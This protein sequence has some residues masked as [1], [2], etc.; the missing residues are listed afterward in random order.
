MN[1][2]IT[3]IV[4]SISLFS[5]NL[6][7]KALEISASTDQC[8]TSHSGYVYDSLLAAQ[9]FP[10]DTVGA[11]LL[12]NKRF[13]RRAIAI[14]KDINVY[15]LLCE[16]VRKIE[17]SN[18]EDI[19]FL[20][21]KQEL[22]QRVAL[23]NNDI[24]SFLA[25]LTCEKARMIE[26]Q[27]SLNAWINRSV[28]RV[29]VASIVVGAAATVAA[30]VISLKEIGDENSNKL[31]QGTAIAGAV[32]GTYLGFKALAS[33][34]KIRFMHTRN[35]LQDFWEEKATSRIY[36]P[37]I[38]NFIN[39]AFNLKG[40]NTTGKNEVLKKW[41]SSNLLKKGETEKEA[42]LMGSG[43]LYS[44]DHLAIRMN[45]Y[46]DIEAEIDLIK[47]DLKRLQQELILVN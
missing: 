8:F 22:N 15:P 23:A 7:R 40:E 29:T 18:K 45:M 25:E 43:G 4:I 28:S 36:P 10:Y 37:T 13:S 47:Y 24:A 42:L 26:T 39:K 27:N 32:V 20:I 1:K 33:K 6:S 9:Q 46:E 3:L 21:L 5:C 2:L 12:A 44:A 16:Y 41:A 34:K 17:A 38:W 31:E 35:H 30:S 11:G 14:A 19:K